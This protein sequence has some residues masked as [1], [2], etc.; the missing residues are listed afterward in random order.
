MWFIAKVT[1][2]NGYNTHSPIKKLG[3]IMQTGDY[4][5]PIGS[6]QLVMFE[7]TTTTNAAVMSRS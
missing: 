1:A 2:K 4:V 3:I 6:Y 7:I 5:M